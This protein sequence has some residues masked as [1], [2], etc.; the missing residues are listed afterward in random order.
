MPRERLILMEK[1]IA[2]LIERHRLHPPKW[3]RMNATNCVEPC[4]DRF[5]INLLWN[6][7]AQSQD[8][9]PV[10]TM[11]FAGQRERTIELNLHPSNRD[12]RAPRSQHGHEIRGRPHRSHRVRARWPYADFENLKD[13]RL[14][15]RPSLFLF[16]VHPKTSTDR[17]RMLH[18]GLD[19]LLVEACVSIEVSPYKLRPDVRLRSRPVIGPHS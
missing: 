2:R 18:E 15:R 17:R 3:H 4:L 19:T 11:S 1:Q 14:H 6:L 10:R 7:A 13:A 5:R 8:D 9:S 16:V 12:E